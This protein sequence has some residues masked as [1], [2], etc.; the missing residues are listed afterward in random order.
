L[1]LQAFSPLA[2]FVEAIPET[3]KDKLEMDHGNSNDNAN[4]FIGDDK[5]ESNDGREINTPS[6]TR[7]LENCEEYPLFCHY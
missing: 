4:I 1:S 3:Q 5:E 2:H 7:H 6:L